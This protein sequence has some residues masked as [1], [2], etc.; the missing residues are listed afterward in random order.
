MKDPFQ[1]VFT[2]FSIGTALSPPVPLTGG[3][4]HKMYRIHTERG[5]W[6]LKCLNPSVMRR[7][8]AAGNIRSAERIARAMSEIIPAASAVPLNGDPLVLL[9]GQY[10]L[11]FA[12]QPGIPLYPPALTP[13]HC[14]AIGGIL[15]RMHAA[16]LTLPGIPAV[17]DEPA[18]PD[19]PALGAA[20]RQVL[21]PWAARFAAMLPQCARWHDAARRAHSN[22]RAACVLSHRDL[23]PKNV[24]WAQDAPCV[25]D[26]EAAGPIHPALEFFT[27][28]RDW[29]CSGGELLVPQLRAMLAAYR[30]AFPGGDTPW[31]D[32][33][34]AS[35]AGVLEWLAYNV[36][37][38]C[39]IEAADAAERELGAAQVMTTLDAL[40][41]YEA[42]SVRMLPL[43]REAP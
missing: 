28:L 13:A 17:I 9:D 36:R 31:E 7:P 15:G 11:L 8:E 26:W 10:F 37:R 39:G 21:K 16:A 22:L 38:A 41:A 35:L 24:L 20:A 14:A 43:L 40:S 34:A 19:W 29:T 42:V 1:A 5:V 3:L 33:A 23:D 2:A 12:W 27:A 25:I 30:A 4:M 6:A 32:A 18:Q